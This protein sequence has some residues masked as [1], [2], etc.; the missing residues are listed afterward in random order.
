MAPI[1]D[2]LS[3]FEQLVKASSK[4]YTDYERKAAKN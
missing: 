3:R 1:K 2:L 4:V